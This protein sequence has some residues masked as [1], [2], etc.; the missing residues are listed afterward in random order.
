MQEA[1]IK[2]AQGLFTGQS[3]K[4]TSKLLLFLKVANQLNS[5]FAGIIY[6]FTIISLHDSLYDNK[7]LEGRCN[8]SSFRQDDRIV[9]QVN[10]T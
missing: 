7:F 1:G 8:L 2:N 4:A 9:F 5:M 10:F 6:N 3:R